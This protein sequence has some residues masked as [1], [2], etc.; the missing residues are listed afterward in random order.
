MGLGKARSDRVRRKGSVLV[1]R[2]KGG[3]G[4]AHRV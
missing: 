4:K 3:C 2:G 1:W